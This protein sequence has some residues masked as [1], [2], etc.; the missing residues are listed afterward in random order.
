M[1]ICL[2]CEY[3]IV[4]PPT[5]HYSE[6]T[7]GEELDLIFCFKICFKRI[8]RIDIWKHNEDDYRKFLSKGKD[9]IEFKKRKI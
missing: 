4:I 9:C 6:Y 5:P 2:D 8:W 3:F 1:K 7:P